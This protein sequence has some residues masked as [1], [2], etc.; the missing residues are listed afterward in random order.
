MTHSDI[1]KA[2][3]QLQSS[4]TIS[5]G[6]VVRGDNYELVPGESITPEQFA[7]A[8]AQVA[9]EQALA[10]SRKIWPTVADFYAEFTP[11]EKYLIQSSVIPSIVVARGDLAMWRG[12]VW[13]DN[14]NVL[15][16]LDAM[17][18][19]GVITKERKTEILTK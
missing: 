3:E 18:E 6:W 16:G 1:V 7:A 17:V 14:P 19:A 15:A 5:V 11:T 2:L 12:D 10:A 4:S 8:L 9:A 13:S